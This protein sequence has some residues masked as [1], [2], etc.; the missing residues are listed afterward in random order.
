MHVK[1][2]SEFEHKY[3]NLFTMG[4]T[5]KVRDETLHGEQTCLGKFMAVVLHGDM[6][7]SFHEEMESFTSAF[8]SI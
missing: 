8:S 3:K 4:C 7:R 1:Y 5:T 6:I 2:T